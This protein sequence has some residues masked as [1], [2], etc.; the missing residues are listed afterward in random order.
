MTSA[1]SDRYRL[2]YR[3][4]CQNSRSNAFR[5]GTS[6]THDGS[7]HVGAHQVS[8]STP[9]GPSRRTRACRV[10]TTGYETWYHPGHPTAVGGLPASKPGLD[11]GAH[12]QNRVYLMKLIRRHRPLGG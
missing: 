1:R 9:G 2:G 8:L 4:W 11:A 10:A 5:E 6:A 12:D 7:A 3:G